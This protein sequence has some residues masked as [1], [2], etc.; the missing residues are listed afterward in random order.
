LKT[1]QRLHAGEKPFLCSGEGCTT[2]YT[3][4]NRTCPEHPYAKPKRTSEIFL[5]PVISASE[6]QEE[7]W[8]WIQKYR[9][10]REEKTPGKQLG[11]L[12]E[13]TPERYGDDSEATPNKVFKSKRVLVGEMEQSVVQVGQEN[14]PSPPRTSYRSDILSQAL[15]KAEEKLKHTN[16]NSFQVLNLQN[17]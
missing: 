6:N 10:E 13:N 5:E 16:S 17:Q 1:H 11:S 15:F 9:K 8:A 2:R 12:S 4:A 3:H 7:V 14:I